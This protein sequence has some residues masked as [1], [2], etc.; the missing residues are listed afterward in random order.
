MSQFPSMHDI[1]LL[2]KQIKTEELAGLLIIAMVA[3]F[4]LVEISQG[5]LSLDKLG[6][7]II[8]ILVVFAIVILVIIR[9]AQSR[10]EAFELKSSQKSRRERMATETAEFLIEFGTELNLDLPSREER[11]SLI[12][13]GLEDSLGILVERYRGK[14]QEQYLADWFEEIAKIPNRALELRN[15]IKY[16]IPKRKKR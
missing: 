9:L 10:Q 16:A 14:K 11:R 5:A 4:G 1:K 12:L 8:A 3:I 6:I 7:V 13:E 15:A 2:L